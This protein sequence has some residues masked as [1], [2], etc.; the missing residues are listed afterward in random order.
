[1]S[2]LALLQQLHELAV[3]LEPSLDG[4]LRYRAPKGVLT[5]P[6][7]DAMRQHKPGLHALVEEG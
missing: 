4:T 6:L 5:P 7:V 3:A 1:M 2:A